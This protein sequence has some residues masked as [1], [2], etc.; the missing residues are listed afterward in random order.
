MNS[1][2]CVRNLNLY[3][4]L[5][6]YSIAKTKKKNHQEGDYRKIQKPYNLVPLIAL[7]P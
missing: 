6:Q 2:I 3:C 4:F 7:S 5:E 1:I